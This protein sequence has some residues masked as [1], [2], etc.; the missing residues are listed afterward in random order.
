MWE[1]FTL[2]WRVRSA[3]EADRRDRMVAAR[4]CPGPCGGDPPFKQGHV[5]CE[6]CL[7]SLH[8]RAWGKPLYDARRAARICVEC[9]GGEDLPEG[10]ATCAGK[11]TASGT[12]GGP[13]SPAAPSAPS[14]GGCIWAKNHR[15]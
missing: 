7:R 10:H 2:H 13:Q 12:G 14:A 8:R 5:F 6:P 3:D 1:V 11:A 9:G 4:R 15:R